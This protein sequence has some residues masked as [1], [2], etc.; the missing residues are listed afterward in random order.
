V[1]YEVVPE[2]GGARGRFTWARLIEMA[3][4]G[5]LA[6]GDLVQGSDG[7][8]RRVSE[9]PELAAVLSPKTAT[10]SE[11]AAATA[12]WADALPACTFLHALARLVFAEDSGLLVAEVGAVRREIYLQGGRPTHVATGLP[13]EGLG[14]YLLHQRAI[15]RG[16]LDMVFAMLPRFEG[17]VQRA[18]VQL[19]ILEDERLAEL[20]EG[21]ARTRLVDLFRW[22]RGTLRFFRGVT[23]AP[24][25]LP[26]QVDPYEV[27]RQ[28][29]QLLEDLAEY[30]S[31][32]LDRAAVP[33][34]L[35][36]RLARL[37]IG[38]V[39]HDLLARADGIA[40]LRGLAQRVA[41]ERRAPTS[42][43]YRALYLLLEVGALELR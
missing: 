42:E 14:E 15:T 10:T 19:G 41:T 22:Q 36:T 5:I 34:A 21:L 25:A 8:T 2:D 6:A 11:V 7:A 16:E 30:F 4:Q 18:V 43:V 37:S 38:P 35:R 39:G 26:V 23:P 12:D 20:V 9:I 32:L 1:F 33:T 24:S 13:S 17:R 40:P 31:P 3:F 29:A 27:L 28:G